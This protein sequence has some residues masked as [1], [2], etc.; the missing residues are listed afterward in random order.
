[1]PDLLD[2]DLFI[3][4]S[5]DDNR[6]GQIS[7]IVARIQKEYR[8]FTGGG[9]LRILFD[10]REFAGMDDWRQNTLD[11]IRSTRLLLVC[12]SPNYLQSE[13]C[14][15]EINQY[16]RHKTAHAPV[17]ENIV[18]FVE[19]PADSDKGF[20]QR[21]AGWVAELQLREHFD[22]RPWFDEGAA[23]LKETAVKD[24]LDNSEAQTQDE[25]GRI[26][27]LI[28]TKGNVDRR[29]DHFVGRTAD[30]S[31]LREIVAFGKAGLLTIINGP[32]GIGKTALA[33]EYAHLFAH[34]YEGGCWQVS[35]GGREDLRVALASLVGVYNLDFSFTE[36]EKRDLD[37]GLERVLSAKPVPTFAQRA[38]GW[39]GARADGTHGPTWRSGSLSFSPCWRS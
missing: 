19:I 35:C 20:E 4:Y 12:L 6:Q 10:K 13:Y 36:E 2:F 30:L 7:E 9:E 16:L 23:D 25:I 5:R 29:N 34:E 1:M 17:T 32:D 18:Y 33:V 8:E 26:R 11:A 31:R 28:E 3:S 27:R 38:P 22:F 14:S 24:L 21:A 37:L 39:R 15:W